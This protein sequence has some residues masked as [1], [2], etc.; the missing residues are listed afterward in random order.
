MADPIENIVSFLKNHNNVKR[1]KVTKPHGK[2][3][4]TIIIVNQSIFHNYSSL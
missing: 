3:M 2:I 1:I 4:K